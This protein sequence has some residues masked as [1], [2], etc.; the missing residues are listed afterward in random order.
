[1][2]ITTLHSSNLKQPAA[3]RN[4]NFFEVQHVPFPWNELLVHVFSSIYETGR[5]ENGLFMWL[6]HQEFSG[7]T[8]TSKLK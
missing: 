3:T 6:I 4:C 1:M 8:R 7:V 5:R 2:I